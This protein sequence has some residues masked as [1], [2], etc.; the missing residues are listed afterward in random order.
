MTNLCLHAGGAL[1]TRDDVIGTDTPAP[2]ATHFPIPHGRLIEGVERYLGDS[3]YTIH[4]QQHALSHMGQRYF[5]VFDLR[6][7]S[8]EDN[9]YGMA[10]GLRNSHDKTFQAALVMGTRVFV[11]DNLSFSGQ[12]QIARKHT[13]FITRDI[14]SLLMK[15][16]G[17]LHD[18][19]GATDTRIAAYKEREIRDEQAHDLI[20]KAVDV[21]AISG[22]QIRPVVNEWRRPTHDAFQP[23]TLWSLFNAFTEVYKQGSL[24]IT[25]SR[26]Q[27]LHGLFDSYVGLAV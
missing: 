11:C 24:E 1:V 16:M 12:V 6:L 10:L 18:H 9:D 4:A 15:A 5:G 27:C 19:K 22:M 20:V 3:G 23:R 14:D 8:G 13:R 25:R 21:R 17:R 26:S 7:S 2:T